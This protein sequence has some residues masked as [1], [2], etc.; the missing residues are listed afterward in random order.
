MQKWYE[1]RLDKTSELSA[2]HHFGL[3]HRKGLHLETASSP[4]Q[5]FSASRQAP[6]RLAW[7]KSEASELFHKLHED[8]GMAGLGLTPTAQMEA[9]QFAQLLLQGLAILKR[10]AKAPKRALSILRY[11]NTYGSYHHIYASVFRVNLPPH[12]MV[13]QTLGPGTTSHH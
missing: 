7:R 9:A 12:G 1:T 10:Q 4:E 6:A 5:P 3:V 13:A 2:D 11:T 8:I